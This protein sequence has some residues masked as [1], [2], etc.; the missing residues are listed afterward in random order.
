MSKPPVEKRIIAFIIDLLIAALIQFVMFLIFI[1]I[2]LSREQMASHMV[3]STNIKITMISFLYILLRDV[4]GGKG[5]GKRMMNLMVRDSSGA[6]CSIWRII[7]RNISLLIWPVEGIV[8]LIDKNRK[9][10]GDKIFHT[11]VFK[12]VS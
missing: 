11:D 4:I 1:I 10:L 9:R 5:I 7:L 3:I 8:I 6:E 12:R 2:P